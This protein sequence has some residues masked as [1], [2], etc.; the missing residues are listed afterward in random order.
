MKRWHAVQVC[1]SD[2]LAQVAAG[3]TFSGALN[4]NG[5]LHVCGT[6]SNNRGVLTRSQPIQARELQQ[7][8][9]VSFDSLSMGFC[10]VGGVTRHGHLAMWGWSGNDLAV[11]PTCL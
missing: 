5:Q 1:R 11:R 8:E 4:R 2:G 7:V 6:D 9:A 3:S 10:S